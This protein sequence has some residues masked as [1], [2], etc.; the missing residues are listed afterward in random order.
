MEHWTQPASVQ[1][2]AQGFG[3]FGHLWTKQHPASPI[4]GPGLDL[5]IIRLH[6]AKNHDPILAAEPKAVSHDHIHLLAP[7]D[8]GHVIKI[9]LRIGGF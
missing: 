2:A 4:T 5:W 7:A 3:E 1:K 8:V 9:T 6:F